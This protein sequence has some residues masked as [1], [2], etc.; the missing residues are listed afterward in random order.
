AAYHQEIFVILVVAA[1]LCLA[2]LAVL[3][4]GKNRAVRSRLKEFARTLF[5]NSVIY[6]MIEGLA[7]ITRKRRILLATLFMSLLIQLLSLL[8]V[9]MLVIMTT[10]ITFS[11]ALSLMAVSSV[12][13]LM[14][15]IP[16]TPGNIGW[17]ELV[18]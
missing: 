15:V 9:L 6:Y 11:Y 2:F 4:W 18:A 5:R 7:V 10:T 12:V 3:L 16:V 1:A 17:T 13:M 14:S 8:G